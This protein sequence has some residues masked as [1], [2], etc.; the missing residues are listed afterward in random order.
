MN[1]FND[2]LYKIRNYKLGE[3]YIFNLIVPFIIA[4]IISFFTSSYGIKRGQLF[5]LALPFSIVVY[6]LLSI[7]STLKER[8]FD[9]KNYYILK[10]SMLYLTY[11]GFTYKGN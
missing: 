8:F 7:P 4:Y 5:L 2:T 10:I 1:T 11:R 9:N 3:Y 6:K